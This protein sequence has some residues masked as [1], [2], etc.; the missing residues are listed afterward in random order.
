MPLESATYISDL[1]PSNPPGTDQKK[2]GDDHIRMQKQVAKNTFPNA[3]KAFYFP[4]S[5]TTKTANFNVVAADMNKVFVMDPTAGAFTATLPALV[6]ADAGWECSF[7][8]IGTSVNPFFILPPSGT[9]QSGDLTGLTRT[10]RAIPGK[11]SKALWTGAVWIVERVVD[12][13]VG[14]ILD[15]PRTALPIGY[16]WANGQ[17]LTVAATNYPDYNAAM[18]S[19]VTSDRRGRGSWGRDDMGGVAAGRLPGALGAAFGQSS[20][21]IAVA[22]LPSYSLPVAIGDLGHSHIGGDIGHLHSIGDGSWLAATATIGG[23]LGAD[24]VALRNA[25]NLTATATGFGNIGVQVGVANISSS[26]VSGGS[27]TALSVLNPGILTNKIVVV[28]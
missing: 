16:E 4:E 12:V 7:I 3:S 6:L 9:L 20:Y 17:T 13:P 21:S 26:V 28:E 22:N 10:R 1:D 27:G 19:G 8:K 23:Q 2:Q 14:T 15:V 5:P 25:V 11:R 18:G 24:Y